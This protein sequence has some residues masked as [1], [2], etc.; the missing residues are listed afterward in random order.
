VALDASKQVLGREVNQKDN[1]KLVKD[2]AEGVK[3]GKSA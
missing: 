3:E 2:F 1:A